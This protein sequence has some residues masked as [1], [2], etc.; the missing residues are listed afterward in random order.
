MTKYF[1]ITFSFIS[2]LAFASGYRIV[3]QDKNDITVLRAFVREDIKVTDVIDINKCQ[4]T[5][6]ERRY[7]TDLRSYECA[8]A[9]A[10][11][12][13]GTPVN[14]HYW[15]RTVGGKFEYMY[16]NTP[17]V[18]VHTLI[19]LEVFERL[20][21]V[22]FSLSNL[23]GTIHKYQK[24]Q[25][26]EIQKV[27]LKDGRVGLVHRFVMPFQA[28][29]GTSHCTIRTVSFK[30]FVTFHDKDS[31]IEY[32]NWDNAKG[33][34]YWTDYSLTNFSYHVDNSRCHSPTKIDRS[35]ELLKQ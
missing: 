26:R 3:D 21:E 6:S 4:L 15:V 12:M 19:P 22:G 9:L 35:S 31:G 8:W 13:N 14:P 32:R 11:G 20:S 29:G 33:S 18:E 1:F 27:T 24:N 10:D 23:G 34:G 25:T 5:F 28:N 7:N 30:P 16:Y 17:V 2:Q